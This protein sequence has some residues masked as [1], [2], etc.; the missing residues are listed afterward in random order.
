MAPRVHLPHWL[1]ALALACVLSAAWAFADWR[2]LSALRLPDTDDAMRLQQVRDWI[3][4]QAFGDLAQQRLADGLVMHWSRIGDLI[5]AAVIVALRP[6]VGQTAAELVAVIAW[7]LAQFTALLMLVASIARILA[8]ASGGIALALAALAYPATTL[9]LP[10]RI[11]HHAL[12][13]LLVLV[14]AR[15]LLAIP[16]WRSGAVAGVAVALAATIGLETLPFAIV[17]GAAIVLGDRDRLAGFGLGLAA[18]LLALLPFAGHGGGCDT[19]RPLVPVA[20]AAALALAAFSRIERQ[21]LAW[22]AAIGGAA[23]ILAWPDARPCLSG[24]YGAVDPLVAR[25]WLGN[26]DEAQPL[27]GASPTHAIGYAGLLVCGLAASAWLARKRGGGWRVLIG[28]QAVALVITLAQ[29]RGAYVGAALAVVPI[30]T[31]IVEQRAAGR[32]VAVLALWIAGAGLTYPILAG[33]LA[34]PAVGPG[35]A[36]CTSP[37]ALA[38]LA[39]LPSGRV[40][41]AIDL[42]AYAIAGTRHAAVAAP[43]HRNNAGNAAMYRFFLG[44]PEQAR[45]IARRWRV[46]YVV[47]CPGDFAEAGAI[48]PRSIAGGATPDW[49]TPVTP[50]VFAVRK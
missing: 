25:L 24:P 2:N 10:G 20:I 29:L 23:A 39:N 36:S 40:I 8:P 33:L 14:Q 48:D 32:L 21:R 28:Y 1:A 47:R 34:R 26:V 31:L 37:E 5:P 12:Q 17:T 15:A 42:G 44:P 3:A 50:T 35:R 45:M 7:P 11:D 19:I 41:A 43:Y 38:A 30:A 13:L 4:G 22:L 6:L 46:D 27:F 49:L 9:F 16:G 18:A